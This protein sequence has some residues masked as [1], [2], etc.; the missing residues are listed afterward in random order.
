MNSAAR[1]DDRFFARTALVMAAMVLLAFPLTYYQ[2]LATGS[3]QFALLHHLHGAAYFAWIGLYVWQ[4][5]M[6][7][8]GR[9]ARHREIGLF[10]LALSGAMLVLGPWMAIHAAQGRMAQNYALPFE[11]TLYNVVD[12]SLF[13]AF[14]AAAMASITRHIEWHRR[15]TFA[16]ALCLV[17]PAISRWFLLMP[18]VFPWAYFGPNIAADMFLVL[19]ALHD[20]KRIGRVHPATVIAAAIMVPVHLATPW[21]SRSA[22][23]N[24]FAPGLLGF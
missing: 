19:L 14:M 15:F 1:K 22:A 18:D 20:R 17:G 2:P 11:F 8:L 23:W 12:V 21:V 10:G 9:T 5:R 16:A 3:R 13:G 24:A 7:A 6:V 4:T